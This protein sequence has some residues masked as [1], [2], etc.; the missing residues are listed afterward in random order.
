[1]GDQTA[2]VH[3]ESPHSPCRPDPVGMHA[4]HL[5]SPAHLSSRGDQPRVL[6]LPPVVVLP[7]H[8]VLQLETHAAG[9]SRS[10]ADVVRDD[11]YVLPGVRPPFRPCAAATV[12]AAGELGTEPVCVSEDPFCRVWIGQRRVVVWQKG[13]SEGD[14]PLR[15]WAGD[16]NALLALRKRI[17]VPETTNHGGCTDSESLSTDGV[18]QRI[19]HAEEGPAAQTSR[20]D[21]QRHGA[22]EGIRLVERGHAVPEDGHAAGSERRSE[23]REVPRRVESVRGEAHGVGPARWDGRAGEDAVLRSSAR[24]CEA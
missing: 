19:L 24:L 7:Q 12:A 20:V 11:L 2:V 6:I 22:E 1:M 13:P 23:V 3:V 9:P 8:P 14:V 18:D 10:E 4:P 21:H 15:S 16:D 5:P 17:L